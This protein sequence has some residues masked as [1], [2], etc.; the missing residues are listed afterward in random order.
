MTFAPETIS[1][2]AS[3]CAGYSASPR[4]AAHSTKPAYAVSASAAR[5]TAS[6]R[7]KG[8]SE[9]VRPE[10]EHRRDRERKDGCRCLRDRLTVARCAHHGGS[11]DGSA[12]AVIRVPGDP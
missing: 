1:M 10:G 2:T 8:T 9:S 4:S 3:S 7:F 6:S 12:S 5:G 11:G